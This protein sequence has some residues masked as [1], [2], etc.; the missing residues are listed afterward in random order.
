MFCILHYISILS[1]HNQY[2]I[3]EFNNDIIMFQFLPFGFDCI[4]NHI[5]YFQFYLNFLWLDKMLAIPF[6]S[7]RVNSPFYAKLSLVPLFPIVKL[8]NTLSHFLN[9]IIVS[10][11]LCIHHACFIFCLH[12]WLDFCVIVK[13]I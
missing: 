7:Y 13:V 3:I 1:L 5:I 4:F 12:L 10:F 2:A 11:L 6:H 8:H 9:L